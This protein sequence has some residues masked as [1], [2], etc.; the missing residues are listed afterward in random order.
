MLR[1]DQHFRRAVDNW[2]TGRKGWTVDELHGSRRHPPQPRR[3]AGLSM[4]DCHGTESGQAIEDSLAD[5]RATTST[6]LRHQPSSHLPTYRPAAG[7]Y[8]RA[9]GLLGCTCGAWE[10]D[11]PSAWL[12]HRQTGHHLAAGGGGA[13][14]TQPITI[15]AALVGLQ[16][17]RPECLSPRRREY[18]ADFADHRDLDSARP[19]EQRLF[20]A[21]RLHAAHCPDCH[22]RTASGR[23]IRLRATSGG[24]GLASDSRGPPRVAAGGGSCT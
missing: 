21:G 22:G 14:M 5:A 11:R 19:G 3:R 20:G 12:R 16:G 8:D 23:L 15:L 13:G 9:A 1:H 17:A 7:L 2:N 18:L 4:S 6:S 10:G 24:S